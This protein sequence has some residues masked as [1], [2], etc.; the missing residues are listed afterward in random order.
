MN[1]VMKGNT[2]FGFSRQKKKKIEYIVYHSKE[3]MNEAE[4]TLPKDYAKFNA[5]IK[6]VFGQKDV[7][8]LEYESGKQVFITDPKIKKAFV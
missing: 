1:E 7:L 3:E 4:K 5:K 6:D 2:V 8:C